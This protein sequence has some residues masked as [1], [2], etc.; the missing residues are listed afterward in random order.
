M[1]IVN[2]YKFG[3]QTP[4]LEIFSFELANKKVLIGNA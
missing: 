3:F 1:K 2:H 4:Y